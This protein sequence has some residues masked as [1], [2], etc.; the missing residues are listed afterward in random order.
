MGFQ[1]SVFIPAENDKNST[2]YVISI[3]QGSLPL[4]SRENYLNKTA[5]KDLLAAYLRYMT[6]VGI[7]LGGDKNDTQRQMQDIIDFET[8]LAN[9][10]VPTEELRDEEKIY[11]NMAL[12]ELQKLSDFVS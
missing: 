3:D 12:S 6:K 11:H 4:P 10:T 2:H 8:K 7:L 9:I 5:N 1:F